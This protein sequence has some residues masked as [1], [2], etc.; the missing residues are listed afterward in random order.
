LVRPSTS[1]LLNVRGTHKIEH[2][3]FSFISRNWRA[4]PLVSVEVIIN[5]IAATTSRAGLEVYA[6]LD[7]RPYPDKVRVSDVEL[8]AVHLHRDTLHPDWNYTIKP[9]T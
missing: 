5:L 1:S 9:R 2:R 8:A 3:L 6:Q 7:P 4:K